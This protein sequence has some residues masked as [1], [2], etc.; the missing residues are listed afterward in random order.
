MAI[1]PAFLLVE[2]LAPSLTATRSGATRAEGTL[3]AQ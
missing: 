2:E 3:S 1:V